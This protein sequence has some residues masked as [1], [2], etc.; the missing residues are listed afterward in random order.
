V[1]GRH[2]GYQ[3]SQRNQHPST[4]LLS[5]ENVN[6]A[7]DAKWYLGKHVAYVYKGQ[8]ADAKG[9]RTRVIWG[10]IT[11][12]HGNSGAVRAK[13]SVALPPASFGSAVRVMLYPSNI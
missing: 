7:V 12:P 13:F 4:S 1:K 11:R 10:K 3:R 2:L 6:T 9:S 5:L 8:K